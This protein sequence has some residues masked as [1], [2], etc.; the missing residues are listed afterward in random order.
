MSLRIGIAQ[1][2][3][4]SDTIPSRVPCQEE[5]HAWTC[6]PRAGSG[7]AGCIRGSTLSSRRRFL[8][9][10]G[11]LSDDS[12][13]GLCTHVRDRSV[14]IWLDPMEHSLR[15]WLAAGND[16]MPRLRGAEVSLAARC[17]AI[18]RHSSK[19]GA[20]LFR[21]TYLLYRTPPL[22]SCVPRLP[23]RRKPSP[24]ESRP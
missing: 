11:R 9:T 5:V 4:R 10:K 21:S 20:C 2:S 17:I 7:T 14:Q 12:A 16:K 23:P 1:T 15:S 13:V 6:P 24:R 22:S 3:E 18:G 19:T 8:C